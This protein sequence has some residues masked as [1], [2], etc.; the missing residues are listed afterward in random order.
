MI[1]E[2]VKRWEEKKDEVRA[3]FEKK[4]PGSYK[5]IVTTV[6]DK[7]SAEEYGAFALD[8]NRITIINH[9]D[10]QGTML[11]VIGEKGYSSDEFYYVKVNYGSCSGCDTLQAVLDYS[12]EIT[13]EKVDG[14][15]TLALHIVQKIKEAE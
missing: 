15:M 12:D 4:L 5:D 3:V 8:P 6:V 14:L 7:I 13:E 1:Q 11:F 10:Y 9:G 2:L